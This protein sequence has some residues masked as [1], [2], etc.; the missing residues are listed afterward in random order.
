MSVGSHAYRH[1]LQRSPSRLD[2]VWI[3]DELLSSTFQR[4]VKGQRRYGSRVPGPLEASKRLAKRRN[5]ALAVGGSSFDPA[6]N[7]AHLFGANGT[8]HV[9]QWDDS[10]WSSRWPEPLELFSYSDQP[11]P[12]PNPSF[13][14]HAE[15]SAE[16]SGDTIEP[17]PSE[18]PTFASSLTS[19]KT[20]HDVKEALE[21]YHIDLRQEPE[22]SRRIFNH[23]YQL[24][25]QENQASSVHELL[26]FMDDSSLNIYGVGNY[27]KLIELLGS[28]SFAAVY[29][30]KLVDNVTKAI[31]LGLVPVREISQILR[32]LPASVCGNG[33]PRHPPEAE[34]LGKVFN[35]VWSSLQSYS[36]FKL[37][38]IDH[39]ILEPWIEQLLFL[40]NDRFLRLAKRILAAYHKSMRSLSYSISLR[41]LDILSSERALVDHN[42]FA[43]YLERALMLGDEASLSYAKDIIVTHHRYERTPLKPIVNTLL[44]YLVTSRYSTDLKGNSAIILPELLCQ[45]NAD[46]ATEYIILMTERLVLTKRED[47]TRAHAL[48]VL[49]NCLLHVDRP[50]L[51]SSHTWSTLKEDGSLSTSKGLRLALRMWTWI[52]LG[53]APHRRPVR[54][55]LVR[56]HQRSVY[57][58]GISI[59]KLFDDVTT[60]IMWQSHGNRSELLP[61]LVAGLQQLDVPSNQ[62]LRKVYTL[63]SHRQIK[64]LSTL[65]YFQKLEEGRLTLEQAALQRDV[66][67]ST[68]H[69]LL[70]SHLRFI[71]NVDVT[72]S[73]FIENMVEMIEKDNGKI[74]D[75]IFLISLHTPLKIALAMASTRNAG[76]IP[77]T[78]RVKAILR[79]ESKGKQ[80]YLEPNACVSFIHLL[81]SSIAISDKVSPRAAFNLVTYLYRYLM[82]HNAPV[83]PNFVRAMYHCGITRFSQNGLRVSGVQEDYIM[84]VVRRHEEPEAAR[85]LMNGSYIERIY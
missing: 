16:A 34:T 13:L 63:L 53:T 37:H 75:M 32:L 59:L 43:T 23:L 26:E 50:T 77:N 18:N 2:Y 84:Q 10:P 80:L 74:R 8:G 49:R 57:A 67:N 15:S 69:Y 9:R 83:K 17:L 54:S 72:S 68:K 12:P 25:S 62:V 5:T 51:L 71:Q 79:L 21:W 58:S 6:A 29:K 39:D 73:D 31:G 76:H 28:A 20:I 3:S 66:F 65:Q 64:N 7:V 33:S 44:Q 4:F 48:K 38:E 27:A 61:K 42:I 22:Q 24:I 78:K 14:A 35:D 45:L 36:V 70:S 52:A 1:A 60:S 85:G 47:N 82:S 55:N 46:V 56:T 30:I 11:P 81:A 19:C 41:A 40:G